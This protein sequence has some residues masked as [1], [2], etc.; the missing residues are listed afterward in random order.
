[1][2]YRSSLFRKMA[3]DYL[4]SGVLPYFQIQVTNDD[5]ASRAGAQTIVYDDCLIS[6]DIVLSLVQAGDEILDEELQGTFEKCQMP[7][8]FTE[9]EGEGL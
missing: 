1:M 9:L 8:Q 4:N 3:I 7:Q 6:G 5:P 2:H